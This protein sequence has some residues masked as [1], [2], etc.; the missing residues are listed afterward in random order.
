VV[1]AGI[2]DI[3]AEIAGHGKVVG[4]LLLL[5]SEILESIQIETGTID[6]RRAARRGMASA[7][8]LPFLACRLRL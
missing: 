7:F 2:R 4:E 1:T 6:P 3:A 5:R 8:P